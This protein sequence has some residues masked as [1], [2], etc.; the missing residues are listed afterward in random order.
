M[1]HFL[2]IEMEKMVVS[3]KFLKTNNYF[4]SYRYSNYKQIGYWYTGN[5]F[6]RLQVPVFEPMHKLQTNLMPVLILQEVPFLAKQHLSE[7]VL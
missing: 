1:I 5:A 6:F 7:G 2:C 3:G 4:C